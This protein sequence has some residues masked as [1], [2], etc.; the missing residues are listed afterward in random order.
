[1]DCSYILGIKCLS[2]T[3]FA[4][5]FSPSMSCLFILWMVSFAMQK[6][7]SVI[8]SHLLLL[9]LQVKRDL[10]KTILVQFMSEKTLC[11]RIFKMSWLN[12]S[13]VEFIC[14]YSMWVILTSL[15]YMRLSRFLSITW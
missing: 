6:L 11:S 8:R 10:C 5:I 7:L 14:V 3:L 13:H 4:N 2:V 1:M 15:G 9:L 12:I